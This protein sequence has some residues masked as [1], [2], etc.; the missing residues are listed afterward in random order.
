MPATAWAVLDGKPHL[1]LPCRAGDP[2]ADSWLPVA[3]TIEFLP[4]AEW[5]PAVVEG[6]AIG[7]GGQGGHVQVDC[8][9]DRLREDTFLRQRVKATGVH[10]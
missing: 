7:A 2:P 10:T 9:L 3:R 4:T 5:A 8:P 1:M 6:H